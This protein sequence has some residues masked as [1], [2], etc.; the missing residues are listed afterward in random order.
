MVFVNTLNRFTPLGKIFKKMKKIDNKSY[1][2]TKIAIKQDNQTIT[3]PIE[4]AENLG[5]HFSTVSSNSN[6]TADFIQYKNEKESEPI[7]FD[8]H[9]N[10]EINEPFNL[11]EF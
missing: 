7:D 10:Q 11:K 9:N 6:Y 1:A 8:T 5:Q 4:V 3:N 2:K